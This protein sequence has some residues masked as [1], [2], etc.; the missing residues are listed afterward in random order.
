[1]SNTRKPAALMQYRRYAVPVV[2]LLALV[3][4]ACSEKP[5]IDHELTATLIQP[6]ARVELKVAA[7]DEAAGDRDGETVY[8]SVCSACH[9][10]GVAG[11][12][13][14]GDNAAWAPRIAKGLDAIVTTA[15]NGVGAMPARGGNPNL[16]DDE[17]R[18]AVIHMANQS[19]A[20][21][22]E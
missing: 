3:L 2:A 11:S 13:K 17:V 5:Q 8:K 21:F 6:V 1:M 22:S 15:I 20:K 14:T 7:A 18:R 10:A 4:A 12:P 16:T 9:S 19:G